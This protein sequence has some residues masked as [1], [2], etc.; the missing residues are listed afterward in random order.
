MCGN[1]QKDESLRD[2]YY[3]LPILY[4][5]RL[6][7]S[8]YKMLVILY[9]R[10]DFKLSIFNFYLIGFSFTHWRSLNDILQTFS[11][12]SSSFSGQNIN[13]EVEEGVFSVYAGPFCHGLFIFYL[14]I[15]KL[16]NLWVKPFSIQGWKVKEQRQNPVWELKEYAKDQV[17]KITSHWASWAIFSVTWWAEANFK[18][19]CGARMLWFCRVGS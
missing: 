4:H 16:S 18:Q 5:N 17:T 12:R 10:P 7:D 9:F 11:R 13:E 15:E 19:A 8:N 14:W 2:L 3:L 1:L 6:L